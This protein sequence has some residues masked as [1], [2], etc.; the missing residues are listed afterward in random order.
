MVEY[1]LR[2]QDSEGRIA[3]ITPLVG[4]MVASGSY[5]SPTTLNG[6]NSY[7]FDIDLPGTDPIKLSNLAVVTKPNAFTYGGYVYTIEYGTT[8][9]RF[10]TMQYFAYS[11]MTY[12]TMDSN[13]IMS[14]WAAG[15]L[16]L[17]DPNTWDK[18]FTF[19][20]IVYWLA[21]WTL[22]TATA[23]RIFP[24][25]MYMVADYSAGAFFPVYSLYGV[26]ST[27]FGISSSIISVIIKE[28]DY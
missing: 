9:N 13:G 5:S 17:G 2:V 24:A 20:S 11:G 23:V 16:T 7:G 6:D 26:P 10:Y 8:P 28:W 21:N 4:S 3:K 14:T 1:A 12:Y 15:N 18:T 25:V 22:G 27:S 19:E